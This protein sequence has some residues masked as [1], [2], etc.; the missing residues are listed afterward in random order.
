MVADNYR[1]AVVEAPSHWGLDHHSQVSTFLPC[2]PGPQGH[3][4]WDT[5]ALD[6]ILDTD[7]YV[8]ICIHTV[9]VLYYVGQIS[10]Y[11]EG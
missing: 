6:D 7:I 2:Y 3:A 1:P 10:G 4:I 9:H 8:Y 5:E 11:L